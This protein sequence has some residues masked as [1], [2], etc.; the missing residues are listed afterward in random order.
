MWLI[1]ISIFVQVITAGGGGAGPAKIA[2]GLCEEDPLYYNQVCDAST[3]TKE[4]SKRQ[5]CADNCVG[6]LLGM[7]VD[8]TVNPCCDA[9]R[10]QLSS[11]EFCQPSSK[12]KKINNYFSESVIKARGAT[13]EERITEKDVVENDSRHL[14]EKKARWRNFI[15]TYFKQHRKITADGG[16]EFI[17]ELFDA[18]MNTVRVCRNT[19]MAVYGVTFNDL[20]T[21]QS[22]VR[23]DKKSAGPSFKTAMPREYMRGVFNDF[24]LDYIHYLVSINSFARLD[25]VIQPS[26]PLFHH[27]HN[28]SLS[29]SQS[30]P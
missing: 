17:Y 30:H 29:V 3:L 15:Q 18:E 4:F 11:L 16:N 13:E 24:G 20:R 12:E 14:A 23:A 2:S 22:Y 5:C 28:H 8:R 7:Q 1:T 10:Q 9:H 21:A 19:W 6:K 26:P 27:I 25:K